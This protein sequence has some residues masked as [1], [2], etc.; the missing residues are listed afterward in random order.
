MCGIGGYLGPAS[1]SALMDTA[2]TLASSLHHR[3]PDANDVFID[4]ADGNNPGLALA[5][6]RLSI[7]DLSELGAQ[8]MSS[9][10]QHFTISYNGELY[11]YL[12]L[13][14]E[15]ID[16]GRQFVSESDTEVVLQA[17][18]H[19]GEAALSRFNGMFALALWDANE[20]T[21]TLAR[22]RFG[23]KPLYYTYNDERLVFASEI[24]SLLSVDALD[25]RLSL[26][27]FY[28]Y[29]YFGNALGSETLFRDCSK[30]PAGSVLT[31]SPG[32]P[33]ELRTFWNPEQQALETHTEQEAVANIRQHLSNSVKRHLVSDVPVGLFLSGGLDSSTLCALASEHYEGQLA[34]YSVDFSGSSAHSELDV[35][36]EVAKCF[37]TE[38]HELN[39]TYDNLES[40]LDKMTT[41]H[42]QPFGDAANIPLYL[43]TEQLPDSVK[44]VLQGDGGD[45]IFGGYKRYRLLEHAR[46]CQLICSL[47]LM[48][49]ELP[50]PTS[51]LRRG[52][53]M[54]KALGSASDAER[55]ARLLTE[56]PG[57]NAVMELISEP[58]RGKLMGHDPFR[59]YQEVVSTLPDK[60]RN[61]PQ[62]LMLWTDTRIL[63]PDHF[64]EK[65]D[66]STMANSVEVRVPFLDTELTDYVM[67][68]PAKLKLQGS[69][70]NLLR[71]AMADQLP[72]SVLH[73][74]KYGFGVPYVEWLRGPLAAYAKERL[75]ADNSLMAELFDQKALQRLWDDHM[76]GSAD[77]GFMIYKLLMF[78]LWAERFNVTLE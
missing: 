21:L 47:P 19:W 60:V 51:V 42:S 67:S 50:L 32:Q 54:L 69:S 73:G 75:F 74:P 15:L 64:L 57:D 59:R 2:R 34:T 44:V 45:E 9:A 78:A 22:D 52:H 26:Q 4:A 68:L 24:Q 33:P 12:E 17:L 48:R 41:A 63:L 38:H 62:Q 20:R 18:I 53:R 16:A 76:S 46:L 43:L 39:V 7:L 56:E 10:D 65:V 70:K 11:N 61:D 66:R 8:P 3:G 55:C 27:G 72:D 1:H 5:H 40:L 49:R 37:G 28:E 71:K 25:R 14:Q 23:I 58:L 35:A 6:T 36:R 13:R 30:L 31:L 77:R 29:L